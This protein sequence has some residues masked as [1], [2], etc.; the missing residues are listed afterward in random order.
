MSENNNTKWVVFI[1]LI[2]DLISFTVILPLFPSILRQYAQNKQDTF[3]SLVQGT[4]HQFRQLVG[5]PDTPRWNSVL[6]GGLLGS[7]FSLMQF[8]SSPLIGA[9]SDVYGRKRVLLLTMFVNAF[10]YLIWAISDNFT[11]FAIARILAGISESNASLSIAIMTDITNK[12]NR[13]KAMALIGI[14]FSIGFVVGPIIGAFITTYK[15][16]TSFIFSPA[17]FCLT[18]IGIEMIYLIIFLKESLPKE[19]RRKSVTSE[20]SNRLSLINPS[21]LFNFSPVNGFKQRDRDLYDNMQQGKMFLF[22]G[23]LMASVQGGYTR[24]IKPGKEI[25][26][27]SFAVFLLIPAFILI[28]FSYSLIQFYIGLSF[29]AIASAV[30]VPCL[31]TVTT[32]IGQENQK[33]AILGILRSLGSLARA[34]GPVFACSGKFQC[35]GVLGPQFAML[36]E[37]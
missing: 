29:Y 6:F 7:I 3:Y 35:S 36:L 33:G 13:G 32:K 23:I 30:V 18:L 25:K 31:T 37:V 2:I 26:T 11:L 20:A 15:S 16:G 27:A 34:S 1:A 5:A 24:R 8:L 21:S 10:S 14:A 22:I 9:L 12:E 28:A 4:V 17:L 19:K